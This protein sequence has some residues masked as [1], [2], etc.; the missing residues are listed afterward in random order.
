MWSHL[1]GQEET[2][3]KGGNPV[4][5]PELVLPSRG[6]SLAG[7]VTF[8]FCVSAIL[9]VLTAPLVLVALVLVKLTSSGPVLYT[10]VRLG[11]RGRPFVIY[12]IRTMYHE[13]ESLT[14]ARWCTPGDSRITPVGHWLR[15]TH[16]DELPQLWNVLRGDMSLVGP[17]P[18]RPE[19]LPMLEQA[20]PH[21]RSRLLVRPGVTG[22]A[23]VQLPPDTDLDSVRSKV[24][25]DLEYVRALDWWLDLRICWAT[26]FKMIGMSFTTIR[27]VFAFPEPKL[28]QSRYL[29]LTK[30]PARPI[31]APPVGVEPTQPV[32][33]MN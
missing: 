31:P 1:V 20:I 33:A 14:G 25:Y 16:I 23:Q 24:A 19:F 15:K 3:P 2:P 12:K 21:Y 9:M 32:P 30:K 10:Q 29:E 7:K 28:V 11:R 5:N 26:F 18:E 17:R 6:S 13:C 27:A 8:D 22:L 4:S